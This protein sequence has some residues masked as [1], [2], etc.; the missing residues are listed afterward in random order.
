MC[1][2]V[3]ANSSMAVTRT[4]K[5]NVV[6]IEIWFMWFANVH[7]EM[8]GMEDTKQLMAPNIVKISKV[9]NRNQLQ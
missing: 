8:V 5:R 7:T 2:N 9:E 3:L 6:W 1:L 4:M